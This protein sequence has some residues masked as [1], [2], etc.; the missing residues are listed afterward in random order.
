MNP[1]PSL[2]T[3]TVSTPD[4]V[5]NIPTHQSTTPYTRDAWANWNTSWDAAAN[6]GSCD[7]D[8]TPAAAPAAAPTP[9]DATPGGNAATEGAAG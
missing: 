6:S 2:L 3:T 7:A 9:D 1:A 5:L 4:G 8:F